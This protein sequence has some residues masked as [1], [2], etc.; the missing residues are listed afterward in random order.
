MCFP[1]HLELYQSL[2]NDTLRCVMY[3]Y[4]ILMHTAHGT[5]S[6]L[7]VHCCVCVC[8]VLLLLLC[9]C[10]RPCS[11][12]S[13][14][15]KLEAGDFIVAATDGLFNNMY[16]NNITDFFRDFRVSLIVSMSYSRAVVIQKYLS[17]VTQVVLADMMGFW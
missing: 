1:F 2:L 7:C 17:N 13:F 4:M 14:S 10:V 11:A 5:S 16:T 9:V 3:C 12:N 8:V 15:L 6:S